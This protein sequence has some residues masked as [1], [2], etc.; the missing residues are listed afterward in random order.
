MQDSSIT[1]TVDFDR[2]GIQHGFL[3]LPYSNDDS[4]WG[5]I[6][7]PL[8]VI[9]NGQGT[10]SLLTGGNHGDEYE[11]ITSLLKLSSTL[12]PDQIRGRVIIIPMM[13]APAVQNASRTSPIDKGNL[14]RSF[15]GNPLGTVTEKIADYFTRYLIPKC[16]FA[17]DIHSGGKTLD[18]LPFAAAH[19]L[20]NPALEELC[21]LGAKLFGAPYTMVMLEMDATSLYDTA[22]E[23]QGKVFVTTELRGG[24]TT[25]PQTI[26][27]ADRGIR[28]FLRFAG[29]L[30]GDY[31]KPDNPTQVLDMPDADCYVQSKHRGIAEYL[32][33]LG[34]NI[35]QGDVIVR[36]YSTERTGE[37]PIEYHA[38]RDGIFAARRFPAMVNIGDTL[39]VIA[40]DCGVVT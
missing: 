12:R 13:N 16:D 17:L 30:S 18:I 34:D 20:N 37:A 24:G 1:A 28:N 26:Q 9:K 32:F 35:S 6:M 38:E 40:K 23:S 22:V 14:N 39:A 19:R 36:I 27:Y 5:S 3:A 10:T 21:I 15:P 33:E 4:A 8:T 7:I 29:N 25:T 2:D 31:E 11:G